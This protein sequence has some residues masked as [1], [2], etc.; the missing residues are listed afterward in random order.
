[1]RSGPEPVIPHG[2][3]TFLSHLGGHLSLDGS[4][5]SVDSVNR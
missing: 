2:G 1:M 5:L 4:I 3:E